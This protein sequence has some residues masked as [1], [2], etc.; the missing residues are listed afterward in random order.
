MTFVNS[1][2]PNQ[3]ED[4]LM[5]ERMSKGI[6]FFS[7]LFISGKA[8]SGFVKFLYNSSSRDLSTLTFVLHKREDLISKENF[9][10][11]KIGHFLTTE[12]LHQQ[13][14]KIKANL[15]NWSS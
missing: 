4:E 3:E 8:I 1:K 7:S 12:K 11:D 5:K 2:L 10:L 9:L 14:K 15:Q 6:S 13:Q